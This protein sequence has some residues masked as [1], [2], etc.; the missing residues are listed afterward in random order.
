[1]RPT[2]LLL[3]LLLLL[4]A[5]PLLAQR[6][7]DD[8]V[9]PDNASRARPALDPDFLRERKGVD[10]HP[11]L[12]SA[13]TINTSFGL[14]TNKSVV[15][16]SSISPP[17]QNESS[18]AINPVTPN[19]LISSAV[20][21]RGAYVYLSTNGGKNWTNKNL[22]VINTNWVSGNDPSVGF[23]YEGNGYV[24]YG[25]FP[26]A[27]NGKPSGESGV[28]LAKTTDN[29]TTWTA[30]IRIIEHKGKMTADSAF[31]DKYYV[32]IDNSATSPRR[33]YM[34][35]PWKRVINS[36]SSTQIV[37]ARST[38]RGLT[39]SAP[40]P[41]SPRRHGTSLDTTFG[42]SFPLTTTG[43][44]GALYVVWN[45]GPVRSIGY[46]KSTDGG[47]T[48]SAPK[49][50]VGGY[51]TL[52]T[53]RRVSS[54]DVY[55]VLKKTFRAETYPTMMADNSN[56]PRRGWIYLAWAAGLHPDIFFIR[57]SDGGATWTNPK[58]IQSDTTNDQWWP[59]LSVDQT[60]GDIAVMYSDSRNDPANI[61]I[62]TYISYSSDGG[63]TWIDR[64]A[65]DVMSDF[66]KT[67]FADTLFAGDYSGN[68]FYAGKIYPSHLDTREDNDVYTALINIHQ[69]Y[70]VENLVAR[71]KAD[72]LRQATVTWSYPVAPTTVFGA[73]LS[74]YSFLITRGASV[75][76][77]L[78]PATM[79][80]VEN[81][82]AP[83]STY[84]YNVSVVAGSDTSAI[85]TVTYRPSDANRP[86]R[87]IIAA[88]HGFTPAISL[89]VT[90]PGVRADS[91][92]PLGNLKGYRIYR[93]G[94][95]LRDV[96]LIPG[97]TGTTV[98]I[99]DAP[100]ERGYYRYAITL[101]DDATP[102]NESLRS[103]SVIIYA[104]DLSAYQEK[105]DGTKPRFLSIG[106]WGI[107]TNIAASA[108]NSITDSP[109][110]L[111][112]AN[113]NTFLQIFP[114]AM[115]K[116][117]ELRFVH[118]VIVDPADSAVVEVSYDSGATWNGLRSFNR[119]SD[120]AWKDSVANPGDWREEI[121]NIQPPHP[122]PDAIGIVR[123]RLKTGTFLNLDGWY[124]DDLA[125]GGPASAPRNS[126]SGGLA[127]EAYPN[128]TGTV[129]FIRYVLPRRGEVSV[130]ILD[131]M[132]N[133]VRSL[134]QGIDEEGA[135]S[136][137]FDATGLPSGVY[138]YEVASG[139]IVERGRVMV[140]H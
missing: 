81:N 74:G 125:F 46:S 103:D 128:P 9:G 68:S 66:R 3:A 26:Q 52:G 134:V 130:R 99:R 63:D 126:G 48:F 22:G 5:S 14:F 115:P 83:D 62:D 73:P 94:V 121:I 54:G 108:P 16:E 70:P 4:S 84:V 10:E 75:I 136:A 11:Y 72:N 120:P 57:S 37:V 119:T 29:G 69:P 76:A 20:D 34:Y 41:V 106:T 102:A 8:E 92:T 111:Y 131:V 137:A 55:H 24:M 105:F 49:Y 122:G 98:T 116:A 118:I 78:P 80:F 38:D 95:I 47:L 135:H 87:P 15:V 12:Q 89:E 79:T 123:F 23:D 67:A 51:P 88:T 65:T 129:S 109:A 39:W 53:A 124:I 7:D 132:G 31:E 64:R 13:P 36:D 101:I 133:Q 60:N 100:A 25:A 140:A 113:K 90:I 6:D 59:W 107:A 82:L 104:G 18:I 77:T 56:S 93:D 28:Y 30:G 110:G 96:P 17:A 61:L 45:D 40:V 58:V 32:Q 86:A 138:F 33:G 114:V 42:Q 2:H 1:M 97:D 112:G 91:S 19:V 21:T 43:P 50:V 27:A 44:D 127:A 85:R 35:T 117:I 139:G 71:G